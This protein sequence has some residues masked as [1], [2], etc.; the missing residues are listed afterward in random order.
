MFK[1]KTKHWAKLDQ[2]VLISE[3]TTKKMSLK[4]SM[5]ELGTDDVLYQAYVQ[6]KDIKAKVKNYIGTPR[7]KSVHKLNLIKEIECSEL[8]QSV[9]LLDNK[10]K[11]RTLVD[12]DY[13]IH[14]ISAKVEQDG[15]VYTLKEQWFTGGGDMHRTFDL[16]K[17]CTSNEKV[18]SGMFEKDT[19]LKVKQLFY[20]LGVQFQNDKDDFGS[21]EEYLD[22]AKPKIA[23][24]D[25]EM[26]EKKAY[27]L[28]HYIN[29]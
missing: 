8:R 25:K 13:I 6:F 10:Y 19:P 5:L 1:V 11:I 4:D 29:R 21:L 18:N 9:A 26:F 22:N 20:D 3:L 16:C 12:N 7:E 2:N 15:I 27:V 28:K 17:L 24:L 14:S 23:Q